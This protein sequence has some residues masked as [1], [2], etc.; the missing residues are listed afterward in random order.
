MK[1]CKRCKKDA[2][3]SNLLMDGICKSC[4]FDEAIDDEF[5]DVHKIVLKMFYILYTNPLYYKLE[6]GLSTAGIEMFKNFKGQ[7]YNA[8]LFKEEFLTLISLAIE[9]EEKLEAHDAIEKAWAEHM[10]KHAN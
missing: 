1:Q 6:G 7:L 5:D 9:H 3:I 4:L 2:F 10:A 8:I